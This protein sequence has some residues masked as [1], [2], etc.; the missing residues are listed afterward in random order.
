MTGLSST[1]A[2]EKSTFDYALGSFSIVSTICPMTVSGWDV[3]R[4]R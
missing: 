4:S 3:L 1:L 2:N